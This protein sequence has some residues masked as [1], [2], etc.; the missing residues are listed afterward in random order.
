MALVDTSV[1]GSELY[2]YTTEGNRSSVVSQ[3][4]CRMDVIRL[5]QR[6]YSKVAVLRGRNAREC[7]SELVGRAFIVSH[8]F[9][10]L[11]VVFNSILPSQYGYFAVGTHF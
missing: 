11:T 2:C 1:E 4:S 7:H 3:A 6:A 10:K 8:G 9:Y 5:G